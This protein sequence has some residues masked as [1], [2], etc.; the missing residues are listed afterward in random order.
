MLETDVRIDWISVTFANKDADNAIP[1]HMAGAYWTDCAPQRGYSLARQSVPHGV[2]DNTHEHRREMGRHVVYGGK[3]LIRLSSVMS[4]LDVLEHTEEHNGRVTRLDLALDVLDSGLSLAALQAQFEAGKCQTRARKIMP[5]GRVGNSQGTLYI[6]SR[7]S[8]AYMRI[9]DKA[10]EIG[11][12]GDRIRI[13]LELKG[14]KAR[15]AARDIQ[16][17]GLAEYILPAIKGFAH[18]AQDEVWPKIFNQVPIEVQTDKDKSSDTRKWLLD[19]CAP[20]LA[21]Q[22]VISGDEKLLDEFWER[23]LENVVQLQ[24]KLEN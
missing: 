15:V 16:R 9:Y 18:F 2:K 11:Q 23:A 17:A 10:A 5:Y 20:A 13:E 8:E 22:S 1:P 3:T 19:V 24:G 4:A 21:K 14:G 7:T 6:G 12:A